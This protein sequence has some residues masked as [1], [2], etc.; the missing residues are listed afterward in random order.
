MAAFEI[1]ASLRGQRLWITG[2]TGFLGKV[3]VEKLL[4]SVPEVGKLLLLIRPGA[5]LSTEER[6]RDEILGTPLFARLRALHG[7]GFDVFVASKV[8]A[9]AGDLG[10]DRFGL[11]ADTY[12]ALCGRVDGVVA[13][14]ATVTFDER[15]DRAFELNTRGACRTLALARDAGN[16]PLLHVSTCFVSGRQRGAISESTV[17]PEPVD[18]E[19]FDLDATLAALEAGARATAGMP[20]SEASAAGS[21]LA[22][23]SGFHDIYT[24]TKTAGELVVE[25]DRGQVPLA[26]LRP[27]IVESAWAEPIPGYLEAIKVTD[28]LLVAYGRGKLRELPGSADTRMELIPVDLVVNA[29]IAALA[30]LQADGSDERPRY[31]QVGSSRHPIRFGELAQYAREGFERMP[32]RDEAGEP[33]ALEPAGFIAP[34]QLRLRLFDQRA[35]ARAR[36]KG[37]GPSPPGDRLTEHFLRLLDVYGPYADHAATYQDDATLNLFRSLSA[38]EQSAFPFDVAAVDWREY[39]VRRH[40][41]GLVRFGLKAEDGAPVPRRGPDAMAERQA[42]GELPMLEGQTLFEVFARV[43]E[44]DPD[45]MALQTFRKGRWLRYTYGQALTTTAN[46]AWRLRG[47]FGIGAGDRVVLWA[48]GSPEWVLATFA[49]HRLGATIVPLDPQWPAAEVVAAA[50]FTE[51]RLICAAPH[52]VAA[53]QEALADDDGIAVATLAAPLIPGPDVG[54]LPGAPALSEAVG[55][56]SDLASIL[57]TSGTTVAPKAV[58]LTHANYLA[59]LR[60]LMPVIRSSRDRLLSVLPIHH[61]FEQMVGLLVP[62]VG[63]GT[64]SYVAELKPTEI[65]WMMNATRPTMLVAVP[66]LLDLLNTG[67][68]A[69][70]AAGGKTLKA[71]FAVLFALSR[72]TGGRHGKKLFGKVHRRFGG[73]LRRIATGGSALEPGLGRTWA[74]MG[75]QVSEGYGM[76]ETSPVLTVNP[77][78][79]I[80]FGSVGKP[81]PGIDFDLRPTEGAAPGSGEIWVRGGNVMAGYYKNPEA[82]AEVLRDG[83]LNTGDIGY[84]DADGYL[85]ISGRSKDVIVT[86]AGKNVFPEEVEARYRGIAGVQELVVLGLPEERGGGERVCA[87]VVPT[88]GATEETFAGIKAAVAARASDVPSY[89][90]I[91]QVI[92]WRGELPKTTTMKVKRARLRAAVLE[93]RLE[94]PPAVAPPAA[95]GSGRTPDQDKLIT[96][97]SLLTGKRADLVRDGDLLTELG[98]DSLTRVELVSEIEKLHPSVR[99]TDDQVAGLVRVADL[100]ALLRR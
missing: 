21:V 8:E 66:R 38:T 82:S 92:P 12:R 9:V 85:H 87:V 16:V 20:D 93:G 74:L 44:A 23:A 96:R 75:F 81:I 61:V 68:R 97:L 70:V 34:D 88:P 26:I 10:Q 94:G 42:R 77:W 14:A 49:V 98:V 1:A 53:L 6:L 4:W 24:L 48:S 83:W 17:A 32:L 35:Q 19:V 39:V 65:S 64:I 41:P 80:R 99:I 29:M 89:Q 79:E 55:T 25:R 46:V 71:L 27:A 69:N 58:P 47:Q 78:D 52:L 76:T 22:K 91:A 73:H 15:L 18:G 59:N 3:L 56:S 28:P 57:F 2:A 86:S 90:Q 63:G 45:T 31:Y 62:I 37:D 11:D 7:D 72:A 95:A 51:A 60:A 50:R 5:G 54:Q 43:A 36:R 40:I 67:I 13:N 33:I 84:F 30:E 100:L